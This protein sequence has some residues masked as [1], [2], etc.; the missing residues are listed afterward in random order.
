[1]PT[2][3]PAGGSADKPR[4]GGTTPPGSTS[5]HKD[6]KILQKNNEN[7]EKMSDQTPSY[8]CC[9]CYALDDLHPESVNMR[10]LTGQESRQG[11][12]RVPARVL[13]ASAVGVTECGPSQA[14]A[15]E[16]PLQIPD[17]CA[18]DPRG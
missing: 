12:L 1:M 5:Q 17:H 4:S 14:R 3:P 18:T 10:D 7:S 6:S 8:L 2:L 13:G 15:R 16:L 9:G 11:G